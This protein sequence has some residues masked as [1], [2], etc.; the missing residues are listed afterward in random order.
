MYK[1]GE[2]GA[3][4]M[5]LPPNMQDEKAEAFGYAFDRQIKKL[6]GK[7][8]QLN[9]WGDIDHV[10]PKFYDAIAAS[11]NAPY[12]KSSY[13]DE[14]KLHLIKNAI[15]SL[16]YGGT[17]RGMNDFIAA[18]FDNAR[19]IPWYRYGGA[20]YHFKIQAQSIETREEF[21]KILKKVKAARS[22]LDTVEEI[23]TVNAEACFVA[24][25]RMR[26]MKNPP[27]RE[28]YSVHEA[29]NTSIHTG[30]AELHRSRAVIKEGTHE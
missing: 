21:N 19:Y 12:Y 2:C 22:I 29:I 14:R 15:L 13:S 11:I 23:S 9:V 7:Y 5:S 30:A 26:W 8:R 24:Y 16:R 18:M 3:T 10:D 28:G 25:T 6:I 4:Y 20:P 17:V 27:I 1:I